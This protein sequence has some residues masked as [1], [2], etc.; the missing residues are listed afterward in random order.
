MATVATVCDVNFYRTQV[1]GKTIEEVVAIAAEL[2]RSEE[3]K[4]VFALAAATVIEELLV[5]VSDPEDPAYRDCT[6]GLHLLRR[7]CGSERFFIPEFGTQLSQ[8]VFSTDPYEGLNQ[9]LVRAADLS[10]RD[11]DRPSAELRAL[12]KVVRQ[13]VEFREKEFIEGFV[14]DIAGAVTNEAE[15]KAARTFF[16]GDV[17]WTLAR[18]LSFVTF[19]LNGVD[20]SASDVEKL[21][22]EIRKN[23]GAS[24]SLFESLI[25][26]SLNPEIKFASPKRNR[27]NYLWDLQVSFLVGQFRFVT[28]DKDVI[29]AGTAAGLGDFV[30]RDADYLAFLAV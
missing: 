25:E 11:G 21:A 23:W 22:G 12:A 1:H 28:N 15:R 3:G 19:K 13:N 6:L 9:R 17:G 8:A 20:P 26:K 14:N 4:G 5:H 24:L 30:M 16:R 29:N 10:L 7:H 27:G 2:R 18:A